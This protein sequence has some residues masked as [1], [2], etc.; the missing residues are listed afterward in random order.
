M[1]RRFEAGPALLSLLGAFAWA[2]IAVLAGMHRAPFGIMELLFLFAILVVVP[3]GMEL[4]GLVNLHLVGRTA[5]VVRALQ[6]LAAFGVVASLWQ[7]PGRLAAALTLPWFLLALSLGLAATASLLRGASRSL[8]RIAVSIACVDLAFG[9]AWGVASRAGWR[10]MG[11]PEPIVLLTAVHYHYS[12]FAT[13]IIAAAALHMF[14][15]HEI[16]L[17]IFRPVVWLVLIL[18]YVV[19]AGFVFSPLLRMVAALAFAASVTVLTGAIVSLSARAQ[20]P[21]ARFFLRMGSGAAWVGMGL[22]GVYAVS[23]HV[24]RAVLTMPG[25]ASTHGVLNGLGFVLLSTLAFLIEL[26][27]RELQG[28]ESSRLSAVGSGSTVPRKRPSGVAQT[29]PEFVAQ[30]FYDR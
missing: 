6:P 2:V 14:G 8:A 17:P 7:P 27:A 4:G 28:K 11:F 13:A 16:R 3:L 10:P 23:D 15:R 30:D 9:S 22:A 26:Q 29:V 5:R 12:G 18:P 24:G 21:T 19:A 25:M 1:V 20:R